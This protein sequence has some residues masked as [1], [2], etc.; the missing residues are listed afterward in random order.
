MGA[1][2]N[3]FEVNTEGNIDIETDK[4]V[5][6]AGETAKVLFKAPFN[7]RMLVTCRNR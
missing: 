4:S 5:Y 2:N 7:G 6:Q 1:N 3:S